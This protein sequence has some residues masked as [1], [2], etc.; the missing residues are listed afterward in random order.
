M[1]NA[2]ASRLSDSNAERPVDTDRPELAPPRETRRECV[3]TETSVEYR[4]RPDGLMDRIDHSTGEV[5]HCYACAKCGEPHEVMLYAEDGYPREG[6]GATWQTEA[7]K[8]LRFCHDC[9]RMKT[10]NRAPQLKAKPLSWI[11]VPP[12]FA[13][14]EL[15][16]F[17][18]H[19][20]KTA[21]RWPALIQRFAVF[22]ASGAG[23]TTLA[24]A[25]IREM[26]RN[27]GRLQYW[28][29]PTLRAR[30]FKLIAEKQST[31]PLY[32]LLC[33]PRP[34]ILDDISRASFSGGWTE[35]LGRVLDDRDRNRAPLMV[36]SMLG[37][38]RLHAEIDKALYRRI[39]Q[40]AE[41]SE[42][43]ASDW[44]K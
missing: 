34:L 23:K 5:I 8:I 13:L 38:K 19:I 1:K 3:G 22:G 9:C 44:T 4:N 11:E 27:N 32:E 29:V 25:L 26:Q 28:D 15:K 12:Q 24:Y 39:T 30:W 41:M 42:L 2:N 43:T 18:P 36:T 10:V 7:G 16:Q 35:F 33:N 40:D 31:E 20:R 21:E 37:P 14:S 6:V 17:K